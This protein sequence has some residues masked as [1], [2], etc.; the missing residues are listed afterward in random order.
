MVTLVLELTGLVISV[1]VVE[2]E[3]EMLGRRAI[4]SVTCH[5]TP[6]LGV[7]VEIGPFAML[8]VV[9]VASELDIEK[10]KPILLAFTAPKLADV[11]T[12][13]MAAAIKIFFI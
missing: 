4:I 6:T 3:Y 5:H 8:G 9:N 10:S 13:A 12:I 11:A 2:D 7:V 1:F